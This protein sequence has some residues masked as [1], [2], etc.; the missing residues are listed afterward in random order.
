LKQVLSRALTRQHFSE[1]IS[2]MRAPFQVIVLPF[3]S[4]PTGSLEFAIFNRSDNRFWQFISGGGES[5]ENLEQAARREA[6]EEGGI[7]DHLRFHLLQTKATIPVYHFAEHVNWPRD[8]YVIQEHAFAVDCTGIQL[9]VSEE[10]SEYRWLDFES[11]S[12]R[13]HWDSNKTALW[14]LNLR[15]SRNELYN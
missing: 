1:E 15:L 9:V 5:G 3:R 13:L 14:E 10:H 6:R 11:A 4:T 2:S 7:P 12:A 8:I